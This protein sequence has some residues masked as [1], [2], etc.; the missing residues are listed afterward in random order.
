MTGGRGDPWRALL[1]HHLVAAVVLTLYGRHVC[2]YAE[3]LPLATW[4]AVLVSAQL[5]SIGARA[6]LLPHALAEHAAAPRRLFTL[7][8][9]IFAATGALVG[10]VNTLALGLPPASGLKLA[11]GCWLYG[12]FVAAETALGLAA[13]RFS[14]ADDAG[15]DPRV[16]F[17]PLWQRLVASAALVIGGMGII[18]FLLLL[19]LVEL[20]DEGALQ[21]DAFVTAVALEMAVA[22]AVAMVLSVRLVKIAAGVIGLALAQQVSTLRAV[23]D[24]RLD[25]AARIGTADEI[26]LVSLELNALVRRLADRTVRLAAAEAATVRALVTVAAVRDS[27]TGR[28]LDRTQ[29]FV[30]LLCE[31]LVARGALAAEAAESIIAAAPLHDIGK[32]GV[33]DAVLNKPGRLSDE[34]MAVMRTHVAQ[35]EAAI[36]RALAE[37][38]PVPLLVTAEAL[39]AGHHE[40]WDGKGYPR[41]LAGEAIPFAGRIMA[42]ADVYDALR[43]PRVYKPPFSREDARRLILEGAGT[44]FDPALVADFSALEPAFDRIAT[45]MADGETPAA[46]A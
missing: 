28:H 14:T 32:V 40:R 44:Q 13:A 3:G 9:V 27:D 6:L 30:R 11:I 16:G 33:P 23:G 29:A 1:A 39:I 42:I 46:A 22:V 26:G 20:R 2:S 12:F 21:S 7:D 18:V 8:W 34:E 31:R 19:R 38:G 45:E 5:L 37:T 35:G 17:R 43:S 15:F 41:G 36:A 10:A 24:G 25:S 4:L